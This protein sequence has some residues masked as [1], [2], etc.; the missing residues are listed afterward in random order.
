MVSCRVRL[1]LFPLLICRRKPLSNMV[2]GNEAVSTF[3]FLAP[4]CFLH[5]ATHAFVSASHSNRTL[6]CPQRVLLRLHPRRVL[7]HDTSSLIASAV[8]AQGLATLMAL[9]WTGY[10]PMPAELRLFAFFTPV[11]AIVVYRSTVGETIAEWMGAMQGAVFGMVITAV[12]RAICGTGS[13]AIGFGV[14]VS[15]F[16]IVRARRLTSIG[17]FLSFPFILFLTLSRCFFVFAPS[18]RTRSV[19]GCPSFPLR[20]RD[21][22]GCSR[23]RTVA[24]LNAR[25]RHLIQIPR[26]PATA[27]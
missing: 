11:I 5:R 16:L 18:V 4:S 20:P 6:A 14:F 17:A 24:F 25:S 15:V 19:K 10:G 8:A 22:W 21:G 2:P 12:A 13:V 1:Y 26:F 9:A 3:S 7:F 27:L 23:M